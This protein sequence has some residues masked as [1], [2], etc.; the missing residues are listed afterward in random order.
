MKVVLSCELATMF[1]QLIW[2][3][4]HNA[5]HQRLHV[6]EFTVHAQNCTPSI[7]AKTTLQTYRFMEEVLH[8]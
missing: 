2:P 5:R 7:K 1:E 4:V 3:V 8:H 6:A